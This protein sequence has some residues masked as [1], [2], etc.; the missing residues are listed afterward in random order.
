MINNTIF[1]M[2]ILLGSTTVYAQENY[3]FGMKDKVNKFIEKSNWEGLISLGSYHD[4]GYYSEKEIMGFNERNEGFGIGLVYT[5]EEKNEHSIKYLKI[6]DSNYNPQHILGYQ[7]M[8][9]ILK[10]DIDLQVGLIGGITSRKL[11][12][13]DRDIIP[14]ILPAI[15]VKMWNTKINIMYVPE[16]DY[17]NNKYGG[18]TYAWMTYEFN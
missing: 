11:E 6:S 10:K 18:F 14:F 15:G 13:G 12:R 3:I 17:K 4:R 7:Y 5:S 1:A 2:M 9:N 16:L 8:L